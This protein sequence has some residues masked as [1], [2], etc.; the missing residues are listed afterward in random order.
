MSVPSVN[1]FL[2]A[3]VIL[4]V[5][6]GLSTVVVEVL[7]RSRFLTT[8]TKTT[9]DD[10]VLRLMR[11]PLHLGFQLIGIFIS[12]QY[13]FPDL[14]YKEYGYS[15]LMPVLLIIWIAYLAN[16]L[17]RGLMNW[18]EDETQ[19]EQGGGIR[20]GTFGFLNTIISLLVWGVAFTF[21]L[22]QLGVDVTA[23]I[24]GLG[25]AGIAV[26]L[27][28]QNTLS[29]LFSAIGLALDRPIRQGDYIRLEDGIEGFVE[30][31]SMRSTRIRTFENTLVIVPNGKLTEM[32]LTNMFLP[33]QETILK[34]PL[35]VSYSADLELVETV[36]I[37]VAK[38]ILANHDSIG[39]KDPFVRFQAFGDSAIELKVF[40]TIKQ[41]L[42][43]YMIKHDFIKALH[44]RFNEEGIEIP[45]PQMRVH[46]KK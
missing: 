39:S 8:K 22:N 13:L 46:L 6:W 43:Q 29:G 9:I 11:R 18:K 12:A 38:E 16:R 36:I 19:K 23:L 45:F 27:A 7:K 17:I 21:M 40:L 30:D 28:L 37:E 42:D 10:E 31:I 25:I 34:I 2:F 26:A 20:R 1:Q 3:G 33:G 5:A 24:A 32:I 41:F 15:D 35:G 44:I 4:V 14:S